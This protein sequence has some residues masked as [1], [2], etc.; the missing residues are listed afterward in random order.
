MQ[1]GLTYCQAFVFHK[2][3][4]DLIYKMGPINGRKN[5]RKIE[6]PTDTPTEFE[7]RGTGADI[8]R[9]ENKRRRKR[10]RNSRGR[11]W[12]GRKPGGQKP[13]IVA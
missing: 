9:R 11:R 4:F 12:R 1:V 7:L 10:Q 5:V 6:V 13:Y 3:C 8:Q 2:H